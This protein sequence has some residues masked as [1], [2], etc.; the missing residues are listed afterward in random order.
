LN[1]F[2]K[3]N[4]KKSMH[5]ISLKD[6]STFLLSACLISNGILAT[7]IKKQESR[8][9]P[10][11]TTALASLLAPAITNV[12]TGLFGSLF[13]PNDYHDVFFHCLKY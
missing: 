6:I 10:I 8:L 11:T 3:K 5:S 13:T 1:I 7:T 2:F 12:I 9:E 4:Q